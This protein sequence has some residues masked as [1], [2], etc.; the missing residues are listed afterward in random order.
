MVTMKALWQKIARRR[1][2][3][4]PVSA[5]RLLVA[6]YAAYVGLFVL[7]KPL[8]M[9]TQPGALWQ[10]A[11]WS[12]MPEVLLHGLVQ[13]LATAGYLTAPVW[14]L[15]LVHT[16]WPRPALL[17]VAR[18]YV[19]L[20]AVV[21]ALTLV[22]D[23]ALYPFWTIKLDAT[24]WNYLDAPGGALSSVTPLYIIG[25]CMAFALTL[26]AVYAVAV[27]PWRHQPAAP[28]H[29]VR[30]TALW[31]VAGGVLFVAIRG[32]VGKGTANVGMV[33][34]S[35]NPFLNHAAVNP[36]FSLVSTTSKT[37]DYG[38][39]ARY[40]DHDTCRRY[41]DAL[42]YDTRSLH[43]PQLLRTQRPH[44]LLILMEGCG[45]T[46][47]HA[48]DPLSD[49]TIT[50][51][52]NRLAAEGVVFTQCYANSFRTDRGTLSTLSGYPAFPD[53]SVMK[54]AA[55]ASTL[56]SIA[57]TLRGAGYSTDFLYGGDLTFT[58]MRGYLVA[59]GYE[60]TTDE[61]DFPASV[62]RSHDWGVTDAITCDTLCQRLLARRTDKPWHTAF[63]TLASHEPWQ[64]PYDRLAGNKV[65]NSMAYLD[66]CIGRLTDRL[67]QSPLWANLLIVL[68]PDHGIG[69]P[70]GLTDLDPR[71]AHIPLI[72]CGGAVREHRTVDVLCNQSDLAATLLGQL[73]LAHD[74]FRFSRDVLSATYR[75]PSAV[76]VWSEGLWHLDAT[77]LS[78][79]STQQ[80]DAAPL[81]EEPQPSEARRRAAKA[82]LQTA[83][84]DLAARD[85]AL[86]NRQAGA[87]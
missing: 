52:L 5:W 28:Q 72:L 67:R 19:A 12:D 31:L 35:A 83:Y 55:L 17:R 71:R 73:G 26:A 56:P 46:F 9:L 68:L 27:L 57:Q 4:A 39:K 60:R 29:R 66:D 84:D 1:P 48:V 7:A 87:H 24:I 33:Y 40:F 25:V 78:A 65:A 77:G 2:H 62:R 36:L 51:H 11:G 64:V 18:P 58:N 15:L 75:H 82:Y 44:V 6:Q 70:E 42:G 37:D 23:A 53:L 85:A 45:G 20:T 10:G 81:R 50:P 69:Y 38:K 21:M 16:W 43:T 80:A 14:L 74:D 76:H 30:R 61:Q 34:Y 86:H 79:V 32:G 13:D 49:P 47:V 63:L 8:F 59:T 3:T 41:F 22:G 54:N